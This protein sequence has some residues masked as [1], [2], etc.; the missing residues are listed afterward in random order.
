MIAP[1][2][3]Y[4]YITPLMIA[5]NMALVA[6]LSVLGDYEPI[7]LWVNWLV[8]GLLS[9]GILHTVARFRLEGGSDVRAFAI[10][11]PIMTVGF[12]FAYCHFSGGSLFY[13]CLVE[14]FAFLCLL[15]LTITFWKEERCV[16]PNIYSGLI[17]GLASAFDAHILLWSLFI[18]LWCRMMRSDDLRNMLGA[19]TGILLG[20][21]VLYCGYFFFGGVH[22]AQALLTHYLE[23]KPDLLLPYATWNIWQWIFLLLTAIV[24]LAYA[25]SGLV[26]FVG[27]TVRISTTVSFFSLLSLVVVALY[28][29]DMQ[30]LCPYLMLL[31]ILLSLQMTIHQSSDHS[32]LQEYFILVFIALGYALCIIQPVLTFFV[33]T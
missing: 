33:A 13:P 14:A 9:W 7:M 29:F 23:L 5:L 6:A 24:V 25:I 19:L 2:S 8:A 31:S 26:S 1:L 30:H 27:Q 20:I 22:A 12:N 3:Q 10:S 15:L 21:W 4:R 17:I 18:P 16:L 32:I 28:F 11:W